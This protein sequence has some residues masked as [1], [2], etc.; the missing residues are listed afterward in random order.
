MQI[1]VSSDHCVCIYIN[2]CV[3]ST[4][5]FKDSKDPNVAHNKY[6]FDSSK[7]MARPIQMQ[8]TFAVRYNECVE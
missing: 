5:D 3:C 6:D 2:I 1:K 7:A 8:G 4:L